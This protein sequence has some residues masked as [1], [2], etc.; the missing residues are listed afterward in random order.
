MK[1][2]AIVGSPRKGSNTDLL[3]DKVIEGARS[4]ADVEVEKI[5][6]Y[7]ADIKYCN[8]CGAHSI[9]QGSKDCPLKD[10]MDGI[11]KRM[12]EADGFIFGTP[13][14]GR[15]ISAGLTNFFSRMM[16]LLKMHVERDSAGNIV[17]A[18]SRP[19]IRGKKA[20]MVVSQG[21][22]V[23]SSSTLVL[24]ILE[25]NLRDFHLRKVGEVFSMFNL[26]RAQVKEK[27]ADLN[28]AF[29][30]GERLATAR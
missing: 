21:D 17:H 7:D 18:E 25:A 16:P 15:T 27:P 13:N 12:Q 24:L 23:A 28:T 22:N 26:Q 2:M 5:Y 8:G 6:V 4:K 30:A 20:V 3:I 19:L 9:L 29:A 1:I 11:L 14:H 10:D